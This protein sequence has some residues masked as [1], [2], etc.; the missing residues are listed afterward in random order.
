LFEGKYKGIINLAIAHLNY[1]EFVYNND[2][3]SDVSV[4]IYN[5][6]IH[7]NNL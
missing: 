1:S 7:T 5:S 4:H 6:L 3:Q 2:I